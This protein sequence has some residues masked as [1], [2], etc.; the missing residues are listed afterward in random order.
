MRSRVANGEIF[1]A[2]LAEP[3]V[4]AGCDVVESLCMNIGQTRWISRMRESFVYFLASGIIQNFFKF[5]LDIG[6]K[7]VLINLVL[8]LL[9]M[10]SVYK[11]NCT[12]ASGKHICI[13]RVTQLHV[14]CCGG[15]HVQCMRH[16]RFYLLDLLQ[17]L[18]KSIGLHSHVCTCM[19]FGSIFINAI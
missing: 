7:Q 14:C 4:R 18:R 8:L 5:S 1:L 9:S 2:S 3:A 12:V 13:R 16:A 17:I 15:V 19:C 10:Y 6:P 11:L